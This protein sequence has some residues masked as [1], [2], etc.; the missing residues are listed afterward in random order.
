MLRAKIPVSAVTVAGYIPCDH[1]RYVLLLH[2]MLTQHIRESLEVTP[3]PKQ[4]LVR[5]CALL[6]KVFVGLRKSTNVSLLQF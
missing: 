4:M 3:G 2:N 5:N 6:V 1:V